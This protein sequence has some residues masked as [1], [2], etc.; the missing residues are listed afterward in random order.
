M[1]T[2][3]EILEAL[4]DF[5]TQCNDNKRLRRM[6]RD[7]TKVLHYV[8]SDTGDTF[9]VTVVSGEGTGVAAGCEG[10]PDVVVETDSETLCDMFW[11]DVNPTRKYMTGEIKVKASQEDVMRVDAITAIIWPEV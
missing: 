5:R 2:S 8:A 6:Q 3:E 1:A 10:T 11:G 4:E 7:W 9:T